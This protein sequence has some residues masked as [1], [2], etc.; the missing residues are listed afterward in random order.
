MIDALEKEELVCR[1][2][3]P[4]DRRKILIRLTE[5]GKEYRDWL[6]EEFEKNAS[7]ILTKL[8]EEDIVAYQKSL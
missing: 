1:R 8:E 7:E 3:D 4:G 6:K 5:K 2:G